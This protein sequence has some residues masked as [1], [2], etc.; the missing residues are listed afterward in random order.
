MNNNE[1]VNKINTVLL[2]N[3]GASTQK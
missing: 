3:I 1:T 2:V